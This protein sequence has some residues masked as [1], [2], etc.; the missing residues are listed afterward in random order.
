MSWGCNSASW[1]VACV[2]PQL[3]R[4]FA[5]KVLMD[6]AAGGSNTSGGGGVRPALPLR[7]F[8]SEWQR[9]LPEG[10]AADMDALRGTVLMEGACCSIVTRAVPLA[11]HCV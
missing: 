10:V 9:T 3:Q 11:V 7:T 8:V 6:K 1:R 4:Y 5:A 2:Y